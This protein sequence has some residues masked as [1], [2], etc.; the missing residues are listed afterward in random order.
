MLCVNVDVYKLVN[1]YKPPLTRLQANLA[2]FPYRYLS[3]GE[4]IARMLTGIMVPTV[5]VEST[6][7]HVWASIN[8]LSS[9]YNPK[10]SDSFHSGRWNSGANPDL[11]F[12]SV[13]SDSRLSEKTCSRELLQVTTSTIVNYTTK[14]CFASAKHAR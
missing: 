12:A 7:L 11:A 5:Q 1:V 6:W 4:F 8:S 9:F 3:A 10:D 14:V 13:D 2:V